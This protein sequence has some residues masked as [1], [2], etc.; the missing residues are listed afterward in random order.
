MADL[1]YWLN[2]RLSPYPQTLTRIYAFPRQ[3]STHSSF[4]ASLCNIAASRM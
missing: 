3:S 2:A 1:M 4:P